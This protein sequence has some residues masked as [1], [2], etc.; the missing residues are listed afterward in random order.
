MKIEQ[1][2]VAAI[3]AVMGLSITITGLTGGRLRGED[4]W[5]FGAM[6]PGMAVSLDTGTIHPAS[7]FLDD[8]G[9][10]SRAL[11]IGE[12]LREGDEACATRVSV[13]VDAGESA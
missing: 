9:V 11:T 10:C 5:S 8:F 2:F 7:Y 6:R 12:M 3:L 13:S 1:G 4:L